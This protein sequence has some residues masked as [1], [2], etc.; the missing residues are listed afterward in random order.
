MVNTAYNNVDFASTDIREGITR[1][2][3]F[4]EFNN[5]T[6]GLFNQNNKERTVTA[7]I[8]YFPIEKQKNKIE[9]LEVQDYLSN[10]FLKYLKINDNFWINLDTVEF[11]I[12]DGVL[13]TS[14]DIYT[15]EDISEELFTDTVHSKENENNENMEN[16]EIT[17]IYTEG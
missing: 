6:T 13:I 10:I 15:V 2:S 17:K 1:P 4:V 7:K 12:V 14:L 3:F 9:L 11:E 8:Y 5:N 16:I